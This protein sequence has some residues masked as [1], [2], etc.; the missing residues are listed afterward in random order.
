MADENNQEAQQAQGP[1]LQMQRVF[2]KDI[3][4]ESPRSPMI[5][6][7]EWKPELGLELNTKSRQV[8]ENVY[9]VVLEITVNVKNEGEPAYLVQVQQ[10]G[11]FTISGLE[12]QQLHHALGAFCPGTLFPYARENIDAIVV[13][14]SFSPVMLAPINFDALY[15]ESLQKQQPEAETTQ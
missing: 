6:Q 7:E 3:S 15:L 1:V 4:F 11:L 9:E 12:E 13:K 10:G 2:L 8:G 5:F 14:G